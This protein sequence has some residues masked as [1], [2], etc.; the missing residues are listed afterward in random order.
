MEKKEFFELIYLEQ[1]TLSEK[2]ETM[3][4]ATLKETFLSLAAEYRNTIDQLNEVAFDKLQLETIESS[5][6]DLLYSQRIDDL[7]RKL[8]DAEAM[9]EEAQGNIYD[10]RLE[11]ES[12][13]Q[14]IDDLRNSHPG[15]RRKKTAQEKQ[16][17]IDYIDAGHS[18]KETAAHFNMSSSTVYN[19]LLEAGRVKARK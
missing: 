5:R 19:I 17:V 9:Y 12:L 14:E 1:K 16:A 6:Q 15:G 11:N 2:L 4:E 13:R 18:Q 10:L 3:D 7:K 8:D